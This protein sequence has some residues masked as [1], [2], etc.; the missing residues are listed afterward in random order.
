MTYIAQLIE[1]VLLPYSEDVVVKSRALNT[2][3]KGLAER[4]IDKPLIKNK[5]F[6]IHIIDREKENN[7]SEVSDSSD[8]ESEEDSSET[9]DEVEE[10]E[11]GDTENETI[12]SETGSEDSHENEQETE[13]PCPSPQLRK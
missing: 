8:S 12:T 1:Y 5:K 3:L 13:N 2:F 10:G 11:V 4:K 9:E 7:R 6:V